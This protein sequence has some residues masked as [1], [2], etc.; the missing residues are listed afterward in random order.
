MTGLGT[1]PS[2]SLTIHA[3]NNILIKG[4][5]WYLWCTVLH[6]TMHDISST[7]ISVNFCD[8]LTLGAFVTSSSDLTT[9][10]ASVTVGATTYSLNDVPTSFE[11][12]FMVAEQTATVACATGYQG[13]DASADTVLTCS[14]EWRP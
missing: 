12:F 3:V 13:T 9:S 2:R 5:H 11:S 1:I 8:S 7:F 4:F 10:T 6:V 14:G